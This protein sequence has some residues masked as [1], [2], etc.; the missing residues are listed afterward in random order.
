MTCRPRYLL[1]LLLCPLGLLIIYLLLPDY[2][3]LN[4]DRTENGEE[5]KDVYIVQRD[6]RVFPDEEGIIH[7]DP[8]PFTLC[9][10]TQEEAQPIIFTVLSDQDQRRK[11]FELCELDRPLYFMDEAFGIP[12]SRS[13][14][15][16]INS[17]SQGILVLD[18][19]FPINHLDKPLAPG[20]SS[21]DAKAFRFTNVVRSGAGVDKE[22]AL[23]VLA[24]T[25]CSIHF[26]SSRPVRFF[27][28]KPMRS[29][30]S[31]K[32]VFPLNPQ[33]QLN[34]KFNQPLAGHSYNQGNEAVQR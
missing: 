19:G 7:L 25:E 24:G 4:L 6:Q 2:T 31:R 34:L 3:Y 28:I 14:L 32:E 30:L 20:S 5:L 29:F 22:E 10:T 9:V 16:L 23:E 21:E 13:W 17:A 33:F 1:S 27:A 11:F 15:L 8:E 18:D 12:G 26:F